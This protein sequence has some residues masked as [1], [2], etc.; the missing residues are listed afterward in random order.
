L[1]KGLHVTPIGVPGSNSM[2]IGNLSA[3]SIGVII[4]IVGSIARIV[5]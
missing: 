4:S 2:L 1:S 5:S 3:I